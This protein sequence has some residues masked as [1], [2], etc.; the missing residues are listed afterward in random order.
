MNADP[1]ARSYPWLE[2]A[3]FGRLLEHCRISFLPAMRH[4]RRVLIFGE[5]DGRFLARFLAENSAATV[6]VVEK[7]RK[8]MVVAEA[9]LAQPDRE[10]VRFLLA[11][12]RD[13]NPLPSRYDLVLTHFF[14]DCLST[15][16]C[17]ALVRRVAS[18]TVEDAEWIV[19]EF[20]I[21][22]SGWG[23]IYAG[24]WV[25]AMY[26][27]FRWVTGLEVRRIPPFAEVLSEH[28][29]VCL[30]RKEWRWGMVQA[31]RYAKRRSPS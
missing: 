27:F 10:R 21:P 8:M 19:S 31:Q 23:R 9:R 29:F 4:A 14:L 12:A 26:T 7:S 28:G 6:D 15:S 16:E 30:D 2:R 13:W 3:A 22:E 5:G 11:D 18:A 17:E 25:A 24:I 20:H 1:L